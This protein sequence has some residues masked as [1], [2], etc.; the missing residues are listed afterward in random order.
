MERET[1]RE[2]KT[3]TGRNLN[4]GR[5]EKRRPRLTWRKVAR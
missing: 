3:G 1:E 5:K 4:D 2:M